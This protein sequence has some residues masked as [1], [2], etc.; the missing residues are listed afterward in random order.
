MQAEEAEKDASVAMSCV[1]NL[2]CPSFFDYFGVEVMAKPYDA[3]MD[4]D[5]DENADVT[6]WLEDLKDPLKVGDEA[7]LKRAKL[8]RARKNF[9]I[10]A[11]SM[12]EKVLGVI[13]VVYNI[14]SILTGHDLGAQTWLF[15]LFQLYLIHEQHD[16][17]KVTYDSC[18]SLCER[19]RDNLRRFT[20]LNINGMKHLHSCAWMAFKHLPNLK[21]FRAG[22]T[23]SSGASGHGGWLDPQGFGG[24]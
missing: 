9:G 20:Q 22:S 16:F 23:S 24:A 7:S 17:V 2:L 21:E 15:L 13:E 12:Q 14:S 10:E 11:K 4:G 6:S 3:C 18:P 8:I 5:F 19:W 1:V